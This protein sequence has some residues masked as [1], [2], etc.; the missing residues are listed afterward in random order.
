MSEAHT[1]VPALEARFRS[2]GV[3]VIEYA[4]CADDLA[5]MD[6]IFPTL[7]PKMAGA[8]ASDFTPA[9]LAWLAGHAV[10]SDLAHRL[11][12]PIA[13]AMRLSRVLAFDTSPE[14]NWFVPWH[15]DRAEGGRYR[16]CTDLEQTVALRIHLDDC[17]KDNGPLEV[18]PGSHVCGRLNSASIA[19]LIETTPPLLCL[20][21]R[22]DIVAMRPLL[23]HRSQRARIPTV[24]RRV[25]HLEYGPR[26]SEPA[27]WAM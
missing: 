16:A 15:Q 24:H 9:A 17:S 5:R 18:L 25:L 14:T 19:G 10:L 21:A 20:A 22:G 4:L 11:A 3:A 12:G 23:V 27:G 6:A 1:P 8:R 26:A 2:F 7:S 13:P